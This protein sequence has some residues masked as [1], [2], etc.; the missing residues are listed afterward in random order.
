V[1]RRLGQ[2]FLT[3]RP[4]AERIAL[5][6]CPGPEPL[7]IEIG[8][9]SGSLTEFLLAR[10]AKVVAIEK[11]PALA[12]RLSEKFSSCTRLEVI[13]ADVLSVD[14]GRWGPA[15]IVGNLPYYITSPI[16]EKILD[17]GSRLERAVI[18]IQ[19]E[20]AERLTAAPG[21][22]AYG[23]L[24]VRTRVFA[25]PEILFLVGPGAFRPPPK[26]DSALVRLTPVSPEQRWGIR[27]PA[28]FL[29]FAAWCFRQKRKTIRNNLERYYGRARLQ[30]FSETSR[31]AEEL[32][33]EQ[34][35]CLY[36]QLGKPVL[37]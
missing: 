20:V 2:H 14:L 31:R 10:A 4:L 19:K 21:R 17:L 8:A 24:T 12:A 35:V 26:V 16:L 18:L 34:L 11:D 23:F 30:A 3:A 9:G 15:V 1:G 37:R 28:G 7:V 22:R 32:S 33:I 29:Q 6:A 13:N 5:V 36:Q 25:E 27:D